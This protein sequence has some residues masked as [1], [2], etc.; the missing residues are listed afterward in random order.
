MKA[1]QM[2]ELAKAR[3]PGNKSRQKQLLHMAYHISADQ[4]AYEAL[5][6][7]QDED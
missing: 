1:D 3:A 7:L 5:K 6:L 2:L 4:E